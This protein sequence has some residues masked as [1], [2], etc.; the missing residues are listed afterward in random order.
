ML[1]NKVEFKFRIVARVIIGK[2][3]ADA[4]QLTKYIIFSQSAFVFFDSDVGKEHLS[5]LDFAECTE[6]PD[7]ENE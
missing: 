6:K 2:Q 5:G 4:F 7:V 1:H 3:I